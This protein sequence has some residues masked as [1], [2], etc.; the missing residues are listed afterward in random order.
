MDRNN[1]ENIEVTWET[2]K[3][4]GNSL[5]PET[6]KYV[7]GT[8]NAGKSTLDV[9]EW[10]DRIVLESLGWKVIYVKLFVK[11]DAPYYRL[12]HTEGEKILEGL[13][14]RSLSDEEID[15]PELWRYIFDS[16]K[17]FPNLWNDPGIRWWFVWEEIFIWWESIDEENASLIVVSQVHNK[18]FHKDFGKYF[19]ACLLGVRD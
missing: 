7:L 19:R 5:S 12:E 4:H 8:T 2:L 1:G 16:L 3:N 10:M 11:G 17:N 18:V 6:Q 9:Y 14:M 13:K 15:S